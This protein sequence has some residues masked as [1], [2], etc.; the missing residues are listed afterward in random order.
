[1]LVLSAQSWLASNPPV[2]MVV[3]ITRTPWASPN[4][5]EVEPGD[6]GLAAVSYVRCEDLAAI[7]PLRLTRRMGQADALTVLKVETVIRR[8]LAL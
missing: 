7:S 1:V 8:L 5:V 2:V 4:R 3:P 6:S